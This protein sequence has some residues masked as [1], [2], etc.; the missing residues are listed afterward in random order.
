MRICNIVDPGPKKQDA[1]LNGKEGRLVP[2][3]KSI[4]FGD[5]GVELDITRKK[6]KIKQTVN[7]LANEF[8][9]IR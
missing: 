6:E 2:K 1:D 4:P 5:V 7:I 9:V 3:L 8:E